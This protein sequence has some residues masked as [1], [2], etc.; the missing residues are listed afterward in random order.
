M[1]NLGAL[2][3]LL[4][5]RELLPNTKQLLNIAVDGI[6]WHLSIRK[7]KEKIK[8]NVYRMLKHSNRSKVWRLSGK[9]LENINPHKV[10]R[11]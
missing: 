11:S 5:H 1:I 7:E 6:S 3:I 10:A 8:G 4:I 9:S 2:S